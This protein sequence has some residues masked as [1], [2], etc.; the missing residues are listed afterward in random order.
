MK[1]ILIAIV[2][3]W[4]VPSDSI[5]NP[6]TTK[7]SFHLSKNL[8]VVNASV[9]GKEGLFILDTGVSEIILN[10][11]YFKG[12]HTKEKFYGVSGNEM[13][14]KIEFIRINLGGF[15]K[16]VVATVVDFT[17]L[18]KATGME[19]LGVIGNSI[20]ATCEVVLDYVFKDLTIY[21]LDKK[22]NRLSPN[23]IHQTPLDT[24]SFIMGRGV[25]FVEVNV[26]GQRLKMSVD[27]GATANVMDIKEIDRLDSNILLIKEGSMASFGSDEVKVES[28]IIE[29]LIVGK[30]SCPPM[31]TL[32]VNLD[33]LNQNRIG[34]RVN[35]ILGY[36]FLC[37]FRIAFN[38][39]KKEIYLWS[40]EFVE[41][42]WAIASMNVGK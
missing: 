42:Q 15:E 33:H 29:K 34:K 26:N 20:F 9:N 35:G 13:V 37:N 30:L 36:E 22:G 38:F 1:A 7:V 39:S 40:R 24:L 8:I 18:E 14:R 17:A 5:S 25:P 32:F 23:S 6:T 2:L 10:D 21:Q 16:K 31:K 12:R 27:S 3:Y 41:Q 28:R 4:G 11:R 19:I